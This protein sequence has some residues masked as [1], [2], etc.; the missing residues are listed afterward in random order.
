M[1]S[2]ALTQN[3]PALVAV[4]VLLMTLVY[5]TILQSAGISNSKPYSTKEDR[6]ELANEIDDM[7][8][9][10]QEEKIVVDV[11]KKEEEGEEL[12]GSYNGNSDEEKT[13]PISKTN[14]IQD[15]I[16][17]DTIY[18]YTSG[19]ENYNK[20]EKLFEEKKFADAK[21]FY[22]YALNTLAAEK[23]Q[24]KMMNYESIYHKFVH[25]FDHMANTPEEAHA[26]L[27]LFMAKCYILKGLNNE[28]MQSLKLSQEFD[29]ENVESMR[30]A[31]QTLNKLGLNH[32]GGEVVRLVPPQKKEERPSQ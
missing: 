16:S 9:D 8:A 31:A 5:F 10:I 11:Q 3:T 14:R 17:V 26:Q 32:G 19:I 6:E 15:G 12:S 25:C 30:L 29:C 7:F 27:H 4:G 20:A 23:G 2:D 18:S 28:A 24:S 22:W 13:E 1:L 21:N